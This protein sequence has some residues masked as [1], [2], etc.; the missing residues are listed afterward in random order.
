M[1]STGANARGNHQAGEEL[2]AHAKGSLPGVAVEGEAPG[3]PCS[4]RLG[5]V[6]P[7][8]KLEA[9]PGR[10]SCLEPQLCQRNASQ[11][12]GRCQGQFTR[13]ECEEWRRDSEGCPEWGLPVQSLQQQH[14]RRWQSRSRPQRGAPFPQ[15]RKTHT[16]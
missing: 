7:V 15:P 6:H 12:Q 10:P 13:G 14:P 8:A 5:A 11:G 16:V 2:W 1:E 4:P 3:H 9:V